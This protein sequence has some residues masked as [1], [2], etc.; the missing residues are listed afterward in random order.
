MSEPST[1]NILFVIMDDVGVDQIPAMGY[2]GLVA[3]EMPSIEA[4]ADGGLRFRNTWSMP[5]CS[6]GRSAL[7]TGRYP[8]R[9]NINQAIG[10]NDLAN[11]QIDPWEMTVPKLLTAA[12]YANAMFGKFHLAGPEHN[13]AGNGTPATLGWDHFFGWTGGL[14]GS[15]DTTAGGVA[16][17]GTYSCGFVPDETRANGA[18]SG[19]CYVATAHGASCT[20]IAGANAAGDSAGLQCLTRGGVLNPG[21]VCEASPPPGLIFNRENAHYVSPLVVN[22]NGAVEEADL[23]DARG[24]GYRST[25]EVNAA[26]DWIKGRSASNT[27]WMATVSFSSAHTPLQHPPGSLV[28]SGANSRLSDDC[29]DPVNQRLLSDAMIEAMDTELGRLLVE[30]GI[31]TRAVDGSLIYDPS[32]SDTMVV[33]V[34]DN[35]SFGPL[36]KLPF[37]AGRA[38]G[39]AYQSG[40]WVPL[41]VAGPLVTSPDRNVEHMVNA[42]DVFRLFGE[43]AGIDVTQAVPRGVDAEQMMPYLTNPAQASI[44]DINFTQG[45]LNIQA[46]GGRNGP[47]VFYGN[48]CSHTPVSKGVCEDNGGAWWGVGADDPSV[49]KPG[50]Q[51]CWQVNQAIYANDSANY[52]TNRITMGATHYQAVRNDE[53]KLVVNRALDYH[54]A[55]DSGVEVVTEEIYRIDQ[56]RTAPRLDREGENLLAGVLTTVEQANYD[57]LKTQLNGLLASQIACP[58]D[59]DGNGVV[60]AKDVTNYT[61]ING[62]WGL[63]SA[64]DFNFDGVTDAQDLQIINDNI[65]ACPQ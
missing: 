28:P 59:G 40:V 34:G 44:R 10:P 37:D 22:R 16:P 39:T 11:S 49:L 45:G 61:A 29:K 14:P 60:D 65:G 30:T 25:I 13:E 48:S 35:G 63:S 55:T 32:A 53:Y 8:M 58:G 7:M 43:I 47:C 36:V 6:P 54:I 18:Y 20:V 9:N 17:A 15:I 19:A 12:G 42:T 4:I 50:L 51:Q 5:E 56:D 27:P 1:P 62:S 38:K 57:A 21:A 52:D 46:N 26:I 64:Y 24:R 2:G 23:R 41:I 33:V 31:A 3:P